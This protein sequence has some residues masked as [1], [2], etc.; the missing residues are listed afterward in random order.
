MKNNHTKVEDF[1][2]IVP[3][4]QV[5]MGKFGVRDVLLDGGSRMNIF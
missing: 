3:I 2:K 4:V 5:Q 1:D